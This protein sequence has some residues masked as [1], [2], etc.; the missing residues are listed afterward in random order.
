MVV[1]R[2]QENVFDVTRPVYV[3]R[4]SEKELAALNEQTDLLADPNSERSEQPTYVTG[5]WR[6]IRPEY[7]VYVGLCTHL[8]C[9][10][11]FRPEVAPADLGNDWKGGFFCPCH[12]SRFDLSGRVFAGVPA[13]TNLDV[14]PYRY[15]TDSVI[16]IGEDQEPA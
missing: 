2:S 13:P 3:V 8:G 15:V 1:P 14:P 10:P 11:K 5:A 6:S 4:R 12:G 16:V 9:A 7:G